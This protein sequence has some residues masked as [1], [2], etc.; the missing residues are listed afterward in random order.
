MYRILRIKM[1][2]AYHAC[3]KRVSIAEHFMDAIIK[4]YSDLYLSSKQNEH[5]N[6]V[7]KTDKD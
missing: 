5:H 4:T 6:F 7:D 3:L 2:I 1:K